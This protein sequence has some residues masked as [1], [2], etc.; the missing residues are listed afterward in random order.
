MNRKPFFHPQ[1]LFEIINSLGM[2]IK[3]ASKRAGHE[4]QLQEFA[5]IVAERTRERC[6]D[7][8]ESAAQHWYEFAMAKDSRVEVGA[9][10]HAAAQLVAKAI[11][12]GKT[13]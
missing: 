5:N 4:A 11:R 7:I 6:A 9:T 13:P 10:A 12:E 2:P 3:W 1:E 8:A